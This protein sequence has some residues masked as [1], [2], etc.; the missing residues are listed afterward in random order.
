MIH[1][2]LCIVHCLLLTFRH[3]WE[4]LFIVHSSLCIVHY[5]LPTAHSRH[6]WEDVFV[7]AIIGHVCCFAAYRLRYTSPMDENAYV[8]H[9]LRVARK[10]HNSPS[11]SL[12]AVDAADMPSPFGV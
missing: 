11:T 3:H 5:S 10:D 7:G 1:C 2:S 4:D 8:P 9:V 12:S 6:H